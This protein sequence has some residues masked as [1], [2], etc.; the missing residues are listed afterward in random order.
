MTESRWVESQLGRPVVKV[1]N[2]IYAKHL[3]EFGCPGRP[4][5]TA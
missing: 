4:V 5:G 1:F 3:M 2:N